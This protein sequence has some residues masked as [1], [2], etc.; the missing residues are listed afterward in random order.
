MS[1]CDPDHIYTKYFEHFVKES[2]RTNA[3]AVEGVLFAAK[4]QLV[5]KGLHPSKILDHSMT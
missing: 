4:Q 2:D 1:H 3:L 5:D